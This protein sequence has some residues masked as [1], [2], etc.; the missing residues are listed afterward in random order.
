M[1]A[2][3]RERGLL[4]G[5]VA[6]S[7]LMTVEELPVR[8]A[9]RAAAAGLHDVRIYLADLQQN[10]LFTLPG[11]DRDPGEPDTLTVEGT[12]AGQAF[13]FGQTLLASAAHTDGAG[14]WWVPLFN[15]T[16]RLGVMRVTAPGDPVTQEDLRLLAG[17]V[18]LVLVSKREMSDS[19]A[20]HIRTRQMN[21]AAEM[22]WHLTPPHTFASR[23]VIVSATQEPAYQVSGDAYDYAF[24]GDSV[25]LGRFDAMGHDT[26]AGL[27]ANLAVAGCRNNRRQG[28]G[29]VETSVAIEQLLIEQFGSS[30][31]VTAL[32]ADLDMTTGELS[33][34]NRG[35]H[36][37]VVIRDDHRPI[38]LDCPPGPPMGTDLDLEIPLSHAQ[39]EPGDRL[40][41][42][43]DGITEA[44]RPTGQE[45][46]L[47]RFLNFVTAS[48]QAGM[49]A[50]E[51]LRRLIH[52]ILSHHESRLGDDATVLLLQW[53]G[54][55]PFSPEEAEALV[56]LP[57]PLGPRVG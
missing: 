6:D 1:H 14:Q 28:Q 42:Y 29:L 20:R 24:A 22:Q 10:L 31:Y 45:F 13:Q 39:L 36:P 27:T 49:P 55:D 34:V 17:L 5:L 54:P 41:L 21:V 19:Y 38:V 16:E 15:G 46:G 12:E 4:G 33:V 50:P 18:A 37:P 56:G 3:D 57:P 43:T 8:V 48:L 51:T 47:E 2:R 52:D 35:H 30:R 32:L 9:E 23:Q 44:R 53:H 26:S 25:H 40:L 11:T 7:H